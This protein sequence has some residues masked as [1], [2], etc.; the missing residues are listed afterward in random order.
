MKALVAAETPAIT[1]VGKTWDFQATN[2]LG[3]SL[4]ENVDMIAESVEYLSRHALVVYDAEH[5][6]DGSKPIHPMRYKR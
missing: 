2:V 5:F 1:V 4:E 6:F 3:V